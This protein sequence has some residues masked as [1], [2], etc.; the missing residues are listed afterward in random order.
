MV[1]FEFLY[2]LIDPVKIRKYKKMSIF[3]ALLIFFATFFMLLLPQKLYLKNHSDYTASIY[4]KTKALYNIKGDN[5]NMFED[6][7]S[8]GYKVSDGKLLSNGE[9]NANIYTFLYTYEENNVCVYLVFDSNEELEEKLKDVNDRYDMIY[10]SEENVNNIGKNKTQICQMAYLESIESLVNLDEVIKKYHDMNSEELNTLVNETPYYR[11][12]GIKDLNSNTNYG[13]VFTKSSVIRTIDK[14]NDIYSYS[15]LSFDS[16]DYKDIGEFGKDVSVQMVARYNEYL[17]NMQIVYV[18]LYTIL[19]PVLAS[20]ILF[21][22]TFKRKKLDNFLEYYKI[23]ALETI[24]P[25]IV[26]CVF[27]FIFGPGATKIFVALF[28]VYSVLMLFRSSTAEPREEHKA[29]NEK[30][31]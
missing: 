29:K 1:I 31:G 25:S 27:I 16:N 4:E 6:I 3:V 18:F 22:F 17:F 14:E 26:S 24:I 8:K 11:F 20:L 28:L 23:L 21:M 5:T 15:Y 30:N 12:Y 7:K 2:N 10:N 19:L 9:S 13:Y